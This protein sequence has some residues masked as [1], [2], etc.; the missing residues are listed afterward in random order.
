[1]PAP[2]EPQAQLPAWTS[3]QRR[4][5]IFLTGLVL[6]YI[7]FRL[8]RDRSTVP[9]PPPFRG[10]R[11][12][13]LRDRIDP[14]TADIATLAALPGLGEKRAAEFV[15]FRQEL[16]RQ[17]PGRPPFAKPEDLLKIKGIGYAMM[18]QL[19]P[20]MVFPSPAAT[21]KSVGTTDRLR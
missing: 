18:M 21:T 2:L 1:M 20:Y 8:V 12:T 6:A 15:Q 7:A 13:E 9:D 11:S 4:V 19:A 3:A 10:A 17:S 14:N 5:L 16:L